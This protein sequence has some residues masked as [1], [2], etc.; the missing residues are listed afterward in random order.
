MTTVVVDRKRHC[1]QGG[2]EAS[3]VW[4][5]YCAA[6]SCLSIRGAKQSTEAFPPHHWTHLATNRMRIALLS[7]NRRCHAARG[8]S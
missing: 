3:P 6:S 8:L 1:P 4:L 5:K 2:E 7:G